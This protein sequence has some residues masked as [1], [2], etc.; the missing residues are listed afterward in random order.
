MLLIP[1]II[2]SAAPQ[3]GDFESIETV[4]V[5]AGGASSITFS[6]IPNTFQHLQIR[7]LAQATT[8]DSSITARINSDSGS[9]YAYHI[10]QGTGTGVGALAQTSQT[11]MAVGYTQDGSTNPSFFAATIIDILDYTNTNK[12]KTV[13]WLSGVDSNGNG[14][15]RY[16]SGLWMS[17]S[18]ITSLTFFIGTGYPPGVSQGNFRQHTHFALYGIR[19]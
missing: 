2:G 16:G 18:A 19:G 8:N 4:T 1:G 7:T 11:Q 6:S 15:L 5:G 9:N 12:N 13:R 3:L 17:T 10:L 14:Q